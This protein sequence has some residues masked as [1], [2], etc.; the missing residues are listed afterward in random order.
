LSSPPEAFYNE[1]KDGKKDKAS[2]SQ[3][4]TGGMKNKPAVHSHGI[5]SSLWSWLW[6]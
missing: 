6:V 5:M 2:L 1:V 3:N 4:E